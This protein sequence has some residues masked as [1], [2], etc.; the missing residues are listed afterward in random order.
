MEGTKAVIQT[1]VKEM[2]GVKNF[3]GTGNT[4]QDAH[5]AGILARKCACFAVDVDDELYSEN[6]V[7]CFNCRYRRWTRVG[8]SCYKGFP[9]K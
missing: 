4:S 1:Y 2:A 6:E 8:F 9:A 5:T 7:S 3:C